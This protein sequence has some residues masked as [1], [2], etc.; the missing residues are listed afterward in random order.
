MRRWLFNLATAV[1]L[2]LFLVVFTGTLCHMLRRPHQR[3]LVEWKTG[4]HEY[5][6]GFKA[7][8]VQLSRSER[9]PAG[10]PSTVV[11]GRSKLV[12]S[13]LLLRYQSADLMDARGNTVHSAVFI[14]IGLPLVLPLVLPMLWLV[15]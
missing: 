15:L 11:G 13:S 10:G 4:S 6:V 1:S 9:W 3:F 2:G 7:L 5:G 14:S 8:G 12:G